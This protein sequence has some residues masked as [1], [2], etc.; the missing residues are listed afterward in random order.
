MPYTQDGN[1]FD[2][3]DIQGTLVRRRTPG[4]PNP[5]AGTATGIP[6]ADPGPGPG[7]PWGDPNFDPTHQQDY[8]PNGLPPDPPPSTTYPKPSG[9]AMPGWDQGKWADAA[10][11]T[12]KYVVGRILSG[13][14]TTP[15]GIQQA[16]SQIL[17][18][19]PGASFD[20]KDILT[21]PGVGSIDVLTGASVGGTGFAW[22]PTTDENGNPL[23]DASGGG[24]AGGGG[25]SYGDSIRSKIM[26]LI[27]QPA[28][29]VDTNPVFQGAIGAYDTQQQRNASRER[30]AIA[31]RMAA[32]GTNTGGGFDDR[33]LGAEQAR[34]E[35]TA[36]FSGNLAVRELERQRDEIMQALNMGVGLMTEEMRLALSEKLG[37]LNASLQQQQ[38]T[39][40]N[41]QF[42][43]N[44][45]WEQ[46]MWEW[47]RNQGIFT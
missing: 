9:S 36:T 15:A 25:G 16:M 38:I 23:S 40:Q 22:Q 35:N 18:A 21:I 44:M 14:P 34:G 2:P 10:H 19:F 29:D 24:G 47:L 41:N 11:N 31:E 28:T 8:F 3:Y 42:N 20:G 46:D 39:N 6:A 13:Y 17:A 7:I 27:N 30:N 12:P 37:M 45:G 26:Q 33:I 32:S 43:Q 4:V 5:Y 1:P